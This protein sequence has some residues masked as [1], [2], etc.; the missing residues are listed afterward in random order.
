MD[1]KHDIAAEEP[2]DL[3]TEELDQVETEEESDAEPQ[4]NAKD[5]IQKIEELRTKLDI[6]EKQ[7]KEYEDKALYAMA[8]MDNA[9]RR[10]QLDVENAHKFGLE[11]FLCSMIP[12][13][14]SLD[15]ALEVKSDASESVAMREGIEMTLKMFIDTVAKV[16]VVRIDPIGEAFDPN[17]HEAMSMQENPDHEPDTIIAVFQRGYQLNGRLIRPARV[18]VSK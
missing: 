15:Q 2:H 3:M 8:E 14:D 1:K 16:G 17:L 9:K 5:I 18:I 13:M 11:K 6:A 12:V 10:A 4:A 7:S